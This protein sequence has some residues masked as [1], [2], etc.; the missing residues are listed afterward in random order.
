MSNTFFLSKN[1][2]KPGEVLTITENCFDGP[3]FKSL[4][5]NIAIVTWVWPGNVTVIWVW[6]VQIVEDWT[7]Y[8][9]NTGWVLLT[10]T[11]DGNPFFMSTQDYQ[12]FTNYEIIFVI[13]LL[14][15]AFLI[16]FAKR[17]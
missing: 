16:R 13:S 5:E 1:F 3:T 9:E 11:E 10:A 2:A 7:I 15:V 14:F 6:E 8:C 12:D 17:S 4:D